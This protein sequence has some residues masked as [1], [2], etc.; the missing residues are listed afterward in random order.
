MLIFWTL[1]HFTGRTDWPAHRHRPPIV[2]VA[3]ANFN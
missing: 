3:H 1:V 2:Q